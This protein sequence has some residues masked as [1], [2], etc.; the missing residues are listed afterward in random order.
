MAYELCMVTESR[1]EVGDNL[2]NP[3]YTRLSACKFKQ[4]NTFNANFNLRL[5][6]E[7]FGCW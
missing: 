1:I 3:Q 7:G 6:E 4:F 2:K 5:E